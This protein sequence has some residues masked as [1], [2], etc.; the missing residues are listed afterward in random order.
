MLNISDS[1][2]VTT[3]GILGKNVPA[4]SINKSW[5]ELEE[6]RM[7]DPWQQAPRATPI[8]SRHL[9]APKC[10]VQTRTQEARWV[11][12]EL[13]ARSQGEAVCIGKLEVERGRG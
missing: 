5:Q 8:A 10:Q 13:D 9:I 2:S 7:D 1:V 3:A 6:R 11:Q 4:W 12:G